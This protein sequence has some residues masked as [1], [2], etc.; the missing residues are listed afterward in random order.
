M[1]FMLRHPIAFIASIYWKNKPDTYQK[2]VA[3]SH[4]NCIRQRVRRYTHKN[5][6]EVLI[7]LAACG[8]IGATLTA[9]FLYWLCDYYLPHIGIN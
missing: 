5:R 4:I 3:I 2:R 7:E 9:A 8:I 1:K 6:K